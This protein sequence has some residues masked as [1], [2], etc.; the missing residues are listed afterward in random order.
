[1]MTD[2]GFPPAPQWFCDAIA[3]CRA[4][5]ARPEW[6]DVPMPPMRWPRETPRRQRKASVRKMIAAAERGGKSVE[7]ITTPDGVTLHFGKVENTEAGNPWLAAIED[8]VTKQ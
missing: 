1:M 8:K 4:A 5:M 6:R 7:S 3:E 2:D